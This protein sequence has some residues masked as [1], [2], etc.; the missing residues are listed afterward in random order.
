[1]TQ[2]DYDAL[3]APDPN[4]LYIIVDNPTGNTVGGWTQLTQAEYDALTPKV[5][6]HLYL[7][8]NP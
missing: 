7:V 2:E 1:M 8:V 4:T 5:A 3:P 6:N